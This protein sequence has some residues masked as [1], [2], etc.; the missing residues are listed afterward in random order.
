[1]VYL[2]HLHVVLWELVHYLCQIAVHGREDGNADGEI[3]CPEEGLP[4]LA[5]QTLHVVAVL[6]HP[7]CRAAHH[8]HV[9]A[10][11]T[12]IVAVCHMWSRKFYCHIG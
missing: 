10:E 7:A 9:V 6:A 12:Q 5:A 11:G 4:F 2:F 8:L 3:R 1:M